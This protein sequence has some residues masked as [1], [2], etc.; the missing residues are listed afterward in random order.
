MIANKTDMSITARIKM[1]SLSVF[2]FIVSVFISLSVSAQD[3][4]AVQDGEALFKAQCASCHAVK[5]KLI[6]PALKGIETRRPEEWLLKWIK[7][8]SA[9]IKSGDEYANKIYNEYNKTQ[10]PSFA[11]KDDEIK[12]ILAYVKT[13]AEKPDAAAVAPAAGDGSAP[14][15][16]APIGLYL[17]IA[18]LVLYVLLTILS[19]VQSTLERAVRQRTGEPEPIQLGRK[20]AFI[21]WARNN[22]KL[23]A[24]ILLVLTGW[25]SVKGWYTLK[26]IGVMQGYTPEQPIK[27]SHKLHA[28]EMQIQCIYCHSGAERGKVAGIPSANVCM[29]CHKYVRKGPQTGTEEIAKIYKALDYDPD[30]GTY[31]PNPKPI[32][33]VRVHNLPDLAYFNHAQHVSV[34]KIACQTCHGPVQD[35]MTVAGQ[36]S[37]LTMGW[38]IDCHRKTEVKMAGNDY[39][40]EYH[41]ELLSKPGADSIITVSEIG[42]LE[43]ARC[44]Y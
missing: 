32:Q 20:E 40:N 12:S 26:N 14:A 43:C 28:G 10:M 7:N 11:L 38:C 41:K 18:G 3:A 4:A 9:V 34:G 19:R 17:I 22:K 35:S 44:H 27:Y 13:E 31:G 2:A 16:E 23:V 42:G 30:K 29:N 1:K 24:V 37:P 8:S 33:W 39:Y 5:E 6:G 15:E 21:H 36:Y 25:G